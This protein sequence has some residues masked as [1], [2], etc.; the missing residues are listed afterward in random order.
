MADDDDVVGMVLG[1][2]REKMEKAIG[3]MATEFSAV[4]TGRAAPSL[5][6]RIRIDYFGSETPLQQL[7]S[8]SAPE[9]RLLVISPYDKSMLKA[10]EK[11]I[12]ESDLGINPSNDGVVIR[13]QI[14]ILT[15]ERRKDLVKQ[16][17]V[18]AE[19]AKVAVRNLRRG[20]RAE[21]D[22]FEKDG[23]VGTD[24]IER[25][26]KAL[27]KLTADQVGDIDRMVAGKEA[28]LLQV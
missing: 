4:R 22:S 17:K 25:A 1:D 28:E 18:K 24:E 12:Q 13:L 15:E 23:D 16:I 21:L 6:D 14:P 8:I 26:E 2:A 19:D 11:A 9:P 5:V 10:M 27:D 3:F 20:A 7:A